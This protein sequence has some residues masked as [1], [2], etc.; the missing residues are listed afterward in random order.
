M[1]GE[2]GANSNFYGKFCTYV[3]NVVD[4][5][6]V[7][8]SCSHGKKWSIEQGRVAVWGEVRAISVDECGV[9]HDH[10]LLKS[11]L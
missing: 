2:G 4:L 11:T 5:N 7:S 9:W 3:S 6:H 1:T 10:E 8:I